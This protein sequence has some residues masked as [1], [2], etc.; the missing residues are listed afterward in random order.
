[1]AC[2]KCG[3]DIQGDQVF[4]ETC[5]EMMEW[6]PVKPG[7]A[8]QLPKRQETPARK[9]V[10]RRSSSLEDQV[11]SLRRAVRI[12]AVSLIIAIVL[13][14]AMAIPTYE[15]LVENIVLPGQ[16]YSTVVPNTSQP[17]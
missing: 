12:L 7:T 4:C 17:Q 13:I 6:Y 2:L 3:R 5:L 10:R 11:K 15:H 9:A 16:N 1:M 14:A 8:V